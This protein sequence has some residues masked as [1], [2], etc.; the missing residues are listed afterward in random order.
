[1]S[2]DNPYFLKNPVLISLI[3]VVFAALTIFI[4]PVNMHAKPFQAVPVVRFAH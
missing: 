1:M 4:D 3:D 2:S